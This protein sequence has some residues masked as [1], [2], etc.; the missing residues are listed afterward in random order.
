MTE[1]ETLSEL[2]RLLHS[3]GEYEVLEFKTA[4]SDFDFG[5]LGKYF[6]A[7]SNEANLAKQRR[8]WL[9]FGVE[10]K[11]HRVV[12][13]QYK[14]SW[15]SLNKL[16]KDLADKTTER[17]SFLGIHELH[18]EGR[19]VLMFEVP[20]APHGVPVAFDGHWY[21]RDHE[22]LVSLNL[23]KLERIR[24]QRIEEDWSAAIVPEATLPDLDPEAIEKA[25]AEFRKK[26]P[27]QAAE[28]DRDDWSDL[29]FLNKAKLTNKGRITRTTLI[30]LGRT[31][32]E[33]FLNPADVKIRWKLKN[34]RGDDLDH[35]VLT[36]PLILSVDTVFNKIRKLKYRYLREPGSLFPEEVD[37]YEAFTIR[38]A[39]NNCIAHLDYRLSGRI[40]VIELP[41]QLVF[42]NKGSFLPGSVERTV[43]ENA[44]EEK[45]R[46]PFL[47]TAMVQVNMVETA[48]G[49]IRK[50]FQYQ[51]DRLFPMPE[52]ELGADRVEVRIAGKVLDLGF[53]TILARNKDLSLEEIILLDK[54][55]KHKQLTDIEIAYLRKRKLVEGR[56]SN[57]YFSLG[58]AKSIGK[59]VDYTR[60][61]GL[62]R[63][64]M[65][66]MLKEGLEQ[67]G[68]LNR[69][70]LD[71][72]LLDYLP[73][74][75]GHEQKRMKLTNLL[76]RLRMQGM[77]ENRGS[78]SRP[79][80]TLTASFKACE[81]EGNK[82]TPHW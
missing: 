46:N 34:E 41:D 71:A 51:R 25:K 37:Q 17:I 12:G 56:R 11:R 32:A 59:K 70:E 21:A 64:A 7:L 76:S 35:A 29:T 81:E 60:N 50:M 65:I 1:T 75:L 19:R 61:K 4:G 14:N 38:E 22:S 36:I 47:T 79:A 6:S 15:Q 63:K 16:K 48:G 40:N 3:R 45:Y 74:S 18:Y 78:R 44:P 62:N 23:E 53:A 33:H 80:W 66:S 43:I 68:E 57:L 52:Y 73:N 67:H 42:T 20:P 5:K 24:A 77:I 69:S 8:A 2:E 13:T 82:R 27:K 55:Q 10:P 26:Y 54:V 49:G 72:L 31:E 30:L 58:L 39:L 28:M 9:V